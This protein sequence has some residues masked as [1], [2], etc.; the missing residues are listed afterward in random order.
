MTT[1]RFIRLG[2]QVLGAAITGVAVAVFVLFVAVVALFVQ[3]YLN[4]YAKVSVTLAVQFADRVVAAIDGHV[5]KHK[6][7]PASLSELS[8]PAGDPGFV[9]R[10]SLDVSTGTLSVVIENGHGKFG[11]VRYVS[12]R[13]NDGSVRWLCQ[14]VSV[15]TDLLPAQCSP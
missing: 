4:L 9:P 3:T 14:N 11:S 6:A 7:L 15:A 10:L 8:L 12:T 5:E 1:A 2:H 13:D